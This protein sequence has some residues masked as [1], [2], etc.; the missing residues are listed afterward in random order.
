MDKLSTHIINLTDELF[1]FVDLKY[2]YQEVNDAYLKLFHTKREDYIGKHVSSVMGKAQFLEIKSF[3]DACFEGE[4][5]MYQKWFEYNQ[6]ERYYLLVTY[7]PYMVDKKIVGA[8]VS[9]KNYTKQKLL[10]EEKIRHKELLLHYSKMAELGSIAS[11]L[12]HQWREPLN[13][14]G[15]TFLK[16]KVL[17]HSHENAT[18]L[19]KSVARCEEILEQISQDLDR[20]RDFYNPNVI[21][22]SIIDVEGSIKQVLSFLDDRISHYDVALGLR[23]IHN[24][25]IR[26][27][28]SDL[29]HLL[30][31]FFNN[32]LDAFERQKIRSPMLDIT[33]KELRGS[34]FITIEDNA[35]GIEEHIL[36]Q[37][38]VNF[39]STKTYT[40]G[41]GMG[42]FFAKIVAQEKLNASLRVK[43]GSHGLK[44]TLEIP[45]FN[46]PLK[47]DV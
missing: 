33:L 1:S 14:L 31:I 36:K 23:M 18:P 2:C 8:I 7:T 47:E 22:Q 12:N 3:L 44:V 21:R 43:N 20:F 37:I 13:T 27:R 40:E 9:V 29:M 35:G 41:S 28:K 24:S 38:F 10:E 11:F 5:I 32:A 42:L 26:G 6:G 16:L 19:Q 25:P 15:A 30:M 46:I 17:S 45:K 39:V 34:V 4:T